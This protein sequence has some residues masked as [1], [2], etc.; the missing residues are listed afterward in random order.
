MGKV[1]RRSHP[2]G[3]IALMCSYLLLATL[4][5]GPRLATVA[6]E[7]RC[8]LDSVDGPISMSPVGAA[9]N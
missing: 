9:T 6:A 3:V 5:R 8:R 4:L 2:G 1:V 7:L